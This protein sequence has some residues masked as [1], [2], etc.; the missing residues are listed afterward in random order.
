MFC[1]LVI[2]RNLSRTSE[3]E[4]IM[5]FSVSRLVHKIKMHPR[6]AQTQEAF[7]SR[8]QRRFDVDL[9]FT[10]AAT[11]FPNR[12]SL[13]TY[14]LH[15]YHHLCPASVREHRE[16]FKQERRGFGEDAFHA[17]WFTVLRQFRPAVCLEIGVYR[18]QSISLWSVIA[19][20]LGFPCEVHGISPFSPIGDDVSTYLQ[21]IDY[22]NDT[23]ASFRAFRLPEP[24]FVRALS[25]DPAALEHIRSRTWDLIY[26]DG[27]HDYDVVVADYKASVAELKPNGLLVMDDASLGTSFD[28]PLFSF[29]G[30]PGPSRVAAEYGMKELTFL[31]AVGHNNVF[32]KGGI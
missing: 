8:H 28:A 13:H 14:F 5:S 29:A 26:I 15:Y 22:L 30:H 1:G 4:Q 31:G 10:Q 32:C 24:V 17:M 25:T 2:L 27:S 23:L 7:Y 11:R 21:N 20:E 3:I 18:G 6:L 9:S 16:Y 19:R 12:N